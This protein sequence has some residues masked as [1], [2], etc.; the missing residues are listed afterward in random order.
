MNLKKHITQIG[1]FFL[2]LSFIG[3]AQVNLFTESP[4][5]FV[6]EATNYPVG[7]YNVQV[8]PGAQI[9]LP[10]GEVR[11]VSFSGKGI[12]QKFLAVAKVNIYAV[13]HYLDQPSALNVQDPIG[14][15]ENTQT[16]FLMLQMTQNLSASDIRNGF[17]DA[18]DINGVDI[19]AP[20]MQSLLSQINFSVNA[21]D[22]IYF[23]G[24]R[25]SEDELE[26]LYVYTDKKTILEKGATLASDFWK[27]WFGT[28]VDKEMA[29]CKKELLTSATF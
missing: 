24:Y 13:L 25:S 7:S 2:T 9:T 16:R 14:S 11:E 3:N 29:A 28:P 8:Y 6:G 21:G 23:V 4:V 20:E 27:I 15:L 17:E 18:L 5:T 19:F 1:F 22:K 10:N 26:H 12:R